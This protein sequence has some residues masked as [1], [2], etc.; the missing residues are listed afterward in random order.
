MSAFH[1]KFQAPGDKGNA[2]VGCYYILSTQQSAWNTVSTQETLIDECLR[3]CTHLSISYE[4]DV[5]AP[6]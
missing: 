4:S 2:Y 1:A 3:T 5:T 6:I